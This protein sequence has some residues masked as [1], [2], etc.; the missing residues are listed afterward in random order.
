MK[1]RYRTALRTGLAG[2]VKAYGFALVIWSGGTLTTAT[3]G[4]PTPLDALAY[5]GGALAG[6]V[7]VILVTFGG[8]VATWEVRPLPRYAF[9]ALHIG[10]VLVALLVAWAAGTLNPSA[11]GFLAAGFTGTV[12]YQVLLGAEIAFSIADRHPH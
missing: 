12:T 4:Q 8:P 5:V 2:E 9:G 7:S 11:L 3:H 1:G 6:M 10:S